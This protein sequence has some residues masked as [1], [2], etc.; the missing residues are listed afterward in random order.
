MRVLVVAPHS[1]DE[2]LG[3]GGT[4]LKLKEEGHTIAWLNVTMAKEEYGQSKEFVSKREKEIVQ[5][6][7]A[8]GFDRFFNLELK[9]A[10]LDVMAQSELIS[11]FSA[12]FREYEPEIVFMPYSR[13]IHSDHRIVSDMIYS[14]TKSFRYPSVKMVLEMETVSETD[15]ARPDE[16]FV[17]NFFVNIEKYMDKKIEI[18]KIYESE[19][20]EAPF[21]RSE[22]NIRSLATVRGCSSGYRYAEGF[23]LI[24]GIW[25]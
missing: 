12:V 2:T 6:Q 14:C 19:I 3:A 22:E 21:P 25:G 7:K 13:D 15:F 4:L 18:M 11:L 24:K 16:G 9:P 20:K 5:V 8:F 17:P 23:K 10:G 1:D